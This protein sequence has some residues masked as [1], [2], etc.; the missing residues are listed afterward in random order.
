MK[1]V[2]QIIIL[3]FVLQASATAQT[4]N[5]NLSA[6]LQ[7]RLDSMLFSFPFTKGMSVGVYCP[8]QGIWEGTSGVSYTGQPITTNMEFGIAS[9]SKL[10]T[11]VILLKLAERNILKLGDSLSK[12]L[13]TY[14]NINPNITIKQLLNHTSGISDPFLTSGLLDSINAHPTH[15]YTPAD[16][17]ALIQAPLFS[18][19][20]SYGYSNANYIIAGMVAQS[21]TGIPIHQLIRDSLLTPL[22]LDSIYY[23][24]K[25]PVYGPIAHRWHDSVDYNDTSRISLNTAGGPAG[26]LFST[27]GN[28]A[29]WYN[30]LMSGQV[31][32]PSSFAQLTT[33][34]SPGNY[35][36]GLGRFTFFGNTCWGHGGSTIG[37]TSRTIYDPCMKV[38]VCGFSNSDYSAVDGSTAMIYKVLVDYLPRCPGN[39]TGSTSVCQGQNSVFYS[40][41]PIV[42]ATSYVWTLPNGATGTSNTNTI[43]INY[44]TSAV[45]SPITIK[46]INMY[47]ESATA[48]LNVTVKPLPSITTTASPAS[49]CTGSSSSLTATGAALYTWQ[50]GALTGASITVTPAATTTYTVTA[51][52]SQGCTKTGTKIVVVTPCSTLYLKLFLEGYYTGNG[53]MR[54][55]LQQ[56]GV[57]NAT[58]TMTDTIVVELRNS[59]FP[60]ALVNSTKTILATNGNVICNFNNTG[61]YYIVVKHRNGVKVWSAIPVSIGSSSVLYDFTTAANKAFGS[62]QKA[63]GAGVFAFYSG[64]I[65]QDENVDLLDDSI[66]ETDINNFTF[67]YF[68]SDINGDGNVDLLDVPIVETN[69][70][71]FIFSNHP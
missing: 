4:F 15:V 5:A 9:N 30:K 67:G 18:A 26:S 47:G 54:N 65:N 25:E 64:D 29:L 2:L 71:A 24:I 52:S 58:S 46:G 60:Y 21:A 11:A 66:L 69:I 37:Y 70:N 53:V 41:P 32:S 14:P 45:S 59:S 39:L 48:S 68:A 62:N 44:T 55:A 20:T 22:S 7:S 17:V 51:T 8:G 42:N 3:F 38:A 28:I 23:D 36:L 12:W 27:A 57:A 63:L 10:F 35:G 40:I 61:S 34:A 13:P 49:I 1:T 43:T 6:K 50:P 16:V 31:L 19:G 56:Q 33:F